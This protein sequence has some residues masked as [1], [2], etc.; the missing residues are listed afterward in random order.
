LSQEQKQETIQEF[1]LTK[2]LVV[3]TISGLCSACFNFGIEAGKDMA[4]AAVAKGC[5]PL[6]QNNVIFIVVLWG[7]FLTN[8][9]YCMY[10][11]FKNKSFGDYGNG[12]APL[13]MNYTFAAVAGTTWFLQF[14]FYGMGESKLGNGASSWILHMATIILT[15]NFWGI[16][17]NEWKGVSK[18]TMR[19]VI[20]GILVILVSVLIVG[21]GNSITD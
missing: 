9:V 3:A 6:F 1:N 18:Q 13:R 17:F 7:G 4:G 2:G 21:F 14:F 16:Y 12:A 19:T 15:S 10:L 20:T 5:D 11:N 8:F